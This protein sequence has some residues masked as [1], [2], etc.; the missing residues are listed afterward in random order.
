MKIFKKDKLFIAVIVVILIAGLYFF[1]TCIPIKYTISKDY[2]GMEYTSDMSIK[3]DSVKLHIFGYYYDYIW[4]KHNTD[5]F[6]GN[7]EIS[8]IPETV[9]EEAYFLM[10]DS[11]IEPNENIKETLLDYVMLD[12]VL[13]EVI[14]ENQFSKMF[15]EL[16]DS[17][18]NNILIFPAENHE[19]AAMLYNEL[20]GALYKK[21]LFTE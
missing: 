11:Y 18:H 12:G 8:S 14:M 3:S 1:A 15:I 20:E 16:S 9:G 19:Q 7:F 13:G 17:Y 6:R 10:H 5:Y 4:E 2:T 21:N